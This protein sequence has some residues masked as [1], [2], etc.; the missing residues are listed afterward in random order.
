M[1]EQ[2]TPSYTLEELHAALLF[3]LENDPSKRSTFTA[4][5]HGV[6]KQ[7]IET[8]VGAA[9]IKQ[10]EVFYTDNTS[11]FERIVAWWREHKSP[12]LTVVNN[13]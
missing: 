6:L 3:Q 12:D 7:I 1:T 9:F 4:Q 5:P 10:F 8:Q 13:E 11:N 2:I